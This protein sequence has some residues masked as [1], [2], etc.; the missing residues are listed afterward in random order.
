M[1]IDPITFLGSLEGWRKGELA[2]PQHLLEE[3]PRWR[4]RAREE[5]HYDVLVWSLMMGEYGFA[6]ALL[7][8]GAQV[9]ARNRGRLTAL[10]F[11]AD[12]RDRR[13][14]LLLLAKGADASQGLVYAVQCWDMPMIDLFLEAGA[15]RKVVTEET[16]S[17]FRIHGQVLR[18]LADAGVDLPKGIVDMLDKRVALGDDGRTSIPDPRPWRGEET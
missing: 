3:Q 13:A 12:Q 15:D 6:E 8:A 10:H 16:V 4:K 14:L 18:H 11:A 9:S 1:R 5:F 17:L 7:D 2:R